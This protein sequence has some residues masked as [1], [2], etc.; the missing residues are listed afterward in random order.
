MDD[1]GFLR[2]ILAAP[3][4]AALRLVYADWLD[5]RGDPRGEYLRCR[6]AR[7]ALRPEDPKHAALLRREQELRR[8]SPAV[9][10]PWERRLLLGRIK[11][12]LGRM[13]PDP[14]TPYPC[15]SDKELLEW[16]A[17]HG[18]TLPEDY[19]LFVR[20]VG[21][22]GTMPGSYCDFVIHPLV[23]QW[24]GPSAATPF[25]VTAERLRAR[26]EELKTQGR[27]ADGVLF[28]ELSAYWEDGQPPG[29]LVF[30]QY[31]SADA[32]FLVTAGEL[33]GSVWCGVCSGIPE[34][35]RSGECTGF[36]AW[37]ANVLAEFESGI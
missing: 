12:L 22:G 29:C 36:L 25:P 17:I 16:E 11:D 31:P 34:M 19:R 13:G 21:D 14:Y 24:G 20:E 6:C 23:E 2:A 27:P 37:F 35:D 10:L 32:L 9:I 1:A 15:L 3:D 30:G 28:P 5:E 8:Q 26:L 7:A 33:R 4:D 18:L